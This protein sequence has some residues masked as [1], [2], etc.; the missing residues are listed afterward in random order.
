MAG[1]RSDSKIYAKSNSKLAAF[2]CSTKKRRVQ[3]AVRAHV[4]V[5]CPHAGVIAGCLR[6]GQPASVVTLTSGR[7]RPAGGVYLFSDLYCTRMCIHML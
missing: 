5:E 4:S 6:K 1:G 7:V 3:S 2:C